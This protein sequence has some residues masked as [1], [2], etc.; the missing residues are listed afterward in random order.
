MSNSGLL[1][2]VPVGGV[3]AHPATV[4][5]G[6]DR[7]LLTPTPSSRKG[8]DEVGNVER[9]QRDTGRAGGTQLNSVVR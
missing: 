7:H 8:V 3:H 2:E 6:N 5:L 1:A 9:K 4:P